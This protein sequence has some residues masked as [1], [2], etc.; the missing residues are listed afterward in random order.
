MAEQLFLK[1]TPRVWVIALCK[2]AL[3]PLMRI[4]YRIKLVDC[5]ATDLKRLDAV[6]RKRVVFVSNHVDR[7]DAVIAFHLS[8]LLSD[9]FY[10]MSN[11]EQLQEGTLYTWLLRSSGVFSIA[12]GVVDIASIKYTTKLLSGGKPVRLFLFPEG[13]AYSRN[14]SAFPFLVQPFD[15]ILRARALLARSRPDETI[16]VV[17]VAIRYEYQKVDAEIAKALIQLEAAVGL[18]I[19]T[20]DVDFVHRLVAIGNALVDSFDRMFD[21]EPQ[22]DEVDVQSKGMRIKRHLVE[23][24]RAQMAE[25]GGEEPNRAKATATTELEDARNVLN[26]LYARHPS[27]RVDKAFAPQTEYEK[28]LRTQSF[29]RMARIFE[30]AHRLENWIALDRDYFREKVTTHRIIDTIVRLEREVFGEVRWS[31]ERT[32]ALRVGDPIDVSNYDAAEQL[33]TNSREQVIA[34]LNS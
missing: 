8:K 25:V 2:A 24:L 13:G 33:A 27:A 6:R 1:A 32:C 30:D 3:N 9:R 21:L 14:D 34:L 20:R 5:P 7:R 28:A 15:L 23:S 16:Y 19:S 10:F 11:R 17:P 29:E 26:E 4:Y 22:A 31:A 12:R 18:P